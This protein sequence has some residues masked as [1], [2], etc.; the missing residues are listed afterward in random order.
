MFSPEAYQLLSFGNCR[1]LES[2]GSHVVERPCPAATA[3]ATDDDAFWDSESE[4]HNH[5]AGDHGYPKPDLRFEGRTGK[6]TWHGKADSDWSCRY[7]LATDK[8]IEFE[9]AATPTGQV[10][11]FPEQAANWDW[12]AKRC[13]AYQKQWSRPPKLLNLFAYTGGSTLA[14]AAMGA[15]VTHVDAAKSVVSWA[16]RN[17]ERSGIGDAPIRWI[18]ED[19][20]KFVTR[21]LKRG[22]HYDGVILDPP[23]YGHGPKREEWKLARDLVEL[24]DDCK[25][26]LSEEPA[27]FLLSC[28]TPGY[29][30]PELSSALTT[31]L[32]GRCGAGVQTRSLDLISKDGMRLPAGHAA[33]W[34]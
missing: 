3:S 14:A 27:L 20:A 29:G 34:P 32:F 25:R 26:L 13:T 21:E 4:D 12:L 18:V 8:A 6:G 7:E 16:R 23:S 22:N 2:F 1:K 31:C 33:Y 10:G 24:L 11:L 15:S 30:E 28:H 19:A 5:D 9:L 17:A